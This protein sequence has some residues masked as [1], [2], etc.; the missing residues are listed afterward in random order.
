MP[1]QLHVRNEACRKILFS[2]DEWKYV[3]WEYSV[4][5]RE[6]RKAVKTLPE[7]IEST[8]KA[9]FWEEVFGG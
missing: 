9:S 5:R 3:E 8:Y 4:R 6:A 2:Y 1:A 7:D